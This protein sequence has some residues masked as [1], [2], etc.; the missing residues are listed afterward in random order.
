VV[1]SLFGFVESANGVQVA[2]TSTAVFGIGFVYCG[3]NMLIYF[4]SI[5][6]MRRVARFETVPVQGKVT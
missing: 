3:I 2:Q 1:I 4:F 5:L 6:G